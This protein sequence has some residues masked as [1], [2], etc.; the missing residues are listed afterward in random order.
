MTH[1]KFFLIYPKEKHCDVEDKRL[2]WE[3]IKL[4]IRDFCIR[5][6]KWIFKDKKGK[7][8]DLPCKLKQL[9]VLLN[10]NPQDT[11]LAKLLPTLYPEDFDREAHS[12]VYRS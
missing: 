8:I 9:N 5:F 12:V 11:K 4:E 6:P 2:H 7:E 3:M 1:L 10:Q